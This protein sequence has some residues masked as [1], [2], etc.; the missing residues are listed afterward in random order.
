VGEILTKSKIL[1]GIQCA[2]RLHFSINHP[3]FALPPNESQKTLF[4]Q[5]IE[6]GKFAQNQFPGGVV[7]SA[8]SFDRDLILKQTAEA[9]NHNGLTLFEAGFLHEGLFVQVDILHRENLDA[10][11]EIIEVKSSTKIKNEHLYD[12]AVQKYVVQNQMFNVQSFSIMT[13]N[14]ECVFPNLENLFSKEDVTNLLVPLETEIASKIALLKK[15]ESQSM[16]SFGDIGA[17]C[18]APY[19]CPYKAH[20]WKPKNIPEVSVFDIPGLATKKKWELYGKGITSLT[21]LTN[22][23]LNVTQKRMVDVS[24]SNTRFVDRPQIKREMSTWKY[25]LHFLDFETMALAVPRFDG[26]HPYQAIPF[27]FSCHVVLTPGATPVHFDYLHD[28]KSDPRKAVLDKILLSIGEDGSVVAYNKSVEA[29]CL[30][31]L[32][33][34]HPEFKNRIDQII[35]RLVD[36]WPVIKSSVY[37]PKFNGSFSIKSVAPSLLG[38]KFEYSRL[39]ISEGTQ[40]SVS[41]ERMIDPTISGEEKAELRKNLLEYCR[42]DTE[43]MYK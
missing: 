23:K 18:D 43:A 21:Q 34:Q 14:S 27:Q 15:V 1:E 39:L 36:P 5:G 9:L 12:L 6:V 10:P 2:K 35:G 42:M 4:N 32:A 3:E 25:P 19:E 40:A 24:I 11:W 13:V 22:E 7:I 31:V 8:P 30:S 26:T 33:E 37:D 38:E 28:D 41:F 17:H 29:R 16:D 20:C